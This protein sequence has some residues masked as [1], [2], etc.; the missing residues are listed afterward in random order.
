MKKCIVCNTLI[1][2]GRL[3]AI[4]TAIT[5]TEHSAAGRKKAIITTLGE[6]DH[7]CNEI[8][9]VDESMF[10]KINYSSEYR[11]FDIDLNNE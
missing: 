4:P 5:C 1:P 8:E 6:G 3:K 2:E 9:I 10:N 7:T 11:N